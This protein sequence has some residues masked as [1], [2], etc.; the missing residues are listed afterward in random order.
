MDDDGAL[1]ER[2]N[3]PFRKYKN[4]NAVVQDFFNGGKGSRRSV[5]AVILRL[6][7]FLTTTSS[8]FNSCFFFGFF[9]LVAQHDRGKRRQ[10][11]PQRLLFPKACLVG[12]FHASA[13]ADVAAAV[14]C[15]IAVEDLFPVSGKGDAYTLAVARYRSEIACHQDHL[16]RLAALAQKR[17]HA[18]LPILEI[19]PFK[20]F[21]VEIKFMQGLG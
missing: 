6:R 15:G 16:M 21:Y 4:N 3:T 9:F 5:L 18:V 1:Q 10:G 20:T 12:G 7:F 14:H 13:I 2:S 8:G 19:D 11:E 17:D